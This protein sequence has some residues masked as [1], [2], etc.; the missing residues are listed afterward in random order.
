MGYES[1][2]SL[3]SS[4][5]SP[6]LKRIFRENNLMI[7][8]ILEFL[9]SD[10]VVCEDNT[11]IHHVFNECMEFGSTNTGDVVRV[12]TDWV[13]QCHG[14]MCLMDLVDHNLSL[15]DIADAMGVSREAIRKHEF[16][17]SSKIR[18]KFSYKG[19]DEIV[20]R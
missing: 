4:L 7:P 16:S 8:Y 14:C 15:Q 3:Y 9:E 5:F 6:E 12:E 13:K 17:A 19:G 1:C 2:A 18:G 20:R 11:C 10:D